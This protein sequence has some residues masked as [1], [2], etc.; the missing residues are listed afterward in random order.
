MKQFINIRI[1]VLSTAAI[2]MT[3]VFCTLAYYRVFRDEVLENLEICI[4]LLSE[5]EM[6]ENKESLEANAEKLYD[7]LRLTL[8]RPD[9]SVVF[10]SVAKPEELDNHKDRVEIEQA[11]KKGEGKSIRRSATINRTNY[12]YA[13]RMEDGSVLRASRESHSIINIFW[14]ALPMIILA[15]IVIDFACFYIS[16][17]WTRRLLAPIEVL[18]DKIDQEGRDCPYPELEPVIAHIRKQHQDIVRNAKIRQD[19][20]ANVSHELKTPLT[21]ISGYAELIANGLT[22]R[23]D[24]LHFAMEIR[25]SGSR[26]LTLIN[27]I[28]RLS[29][30]DISGP[31][32]FEMEEV[33]LYE[34]A[35]TCGEMMGL[36]AEDHDVNLHVEG[37]KTMV[38]A[39]KDMMEEI[40][41][42]L[43]DNAIRYNKPGGSVTILVKDRTLCV[44]DTGIGIP[45]QYQSRVFERF[46]RVD[47]S[48]SRKTGGTG[49]GLAIVKHIAGVHGASI[50]MESQPGQ[51]TEIVIRFKENH[52]G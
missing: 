26:L 45:D 47:K 32:D 33:D 41:Y 1:M 31:N 3:A 44:R 2:L 21:A 46:F 11:M 13:I 48:R 27:D 50:H 25:K 35:L 12:Y 17:L 8:I 19:F 24:T 51:G 4:R 9:G 36:K 7:D 29:E 10:D 34:I 6:I 52:R 23:E 14:H 22:N 20:T 42:N 15:V 43:C 49:L 5:K 39:N 28:L 16:R 38:M 37:E 40:V 18:A 30:F